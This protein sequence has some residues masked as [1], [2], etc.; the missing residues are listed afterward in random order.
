MRVMVASVLLALSPVAL[1][2]LTWKWMVPL[3]GMFSIKAC[4]SDQPSALACW[5]AA[6]SA[7]SANEDA[8][9]VGIVSFS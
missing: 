2:A 3:A 5:K 4:L 6:K 9:T 1:C 7:R 8:V